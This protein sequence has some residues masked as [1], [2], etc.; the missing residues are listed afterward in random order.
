MFRPS[1]DH[2]GQGRRVDLAEKIAT[3]SGESITGW[4]T[5]EKKNKEKKVEKLKT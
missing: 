4:T 1:D 3:T 5:G 2:S